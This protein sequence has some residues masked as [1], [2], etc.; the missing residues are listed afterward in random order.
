MSTLLE[1]LSGG[2]RRS[3]GRSEEVA[4]AVI[5]NPSL[6]SQ[7]FDGMLDTDPIVR[8]CAADAVEKVTAKHPDWLKPYKRKLLGPIAAIDQQEVRWHLAQMLP[9]LQLSVQQRRE[10]TNILLGYVNDESSITRTFALQALADLAKD[11][12]RLRQEVIGLLKD[13]TR[14]GTSA[15]KSRAKNLLKKLDA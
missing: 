1:K 13:A 5:E 15:M 6:F 2:D 9:R 3:I 12:L 10:A 11:D 4:A 8:M 14:S 7:L